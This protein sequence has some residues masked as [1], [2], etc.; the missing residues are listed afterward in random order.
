M[1]GPLI[2]TPETA[3]RLARAIISD[4]II[5]NRE[6]IK[7]GIK[8]DNLFEVLEKELKEGQGL[9]ES[10]V[11]PELARKTNFFN[12]VIVDILIKRCGDIE[13]EIW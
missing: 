13:S 1:P 8:N 5:Y 10:R 4:I 6:K 2:T 11:D 3:M 7:E 12:R 9:Y